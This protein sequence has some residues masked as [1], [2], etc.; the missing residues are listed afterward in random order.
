MY[1]KSNIFIYTKAVS[2]DADSPNKHEM[3]PTSIR[4]LTK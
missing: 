3:R 4:F 2:K 1:K